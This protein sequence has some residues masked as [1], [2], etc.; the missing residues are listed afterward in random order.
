[1]KQGRMFAG[2][3]ICA[4]SLL[5]SFMLPQQVSSAEK[6]TFSGAKPTEYP[7][8]FKESFLEFAD[9]I[10]ESTEQGKRV[11][12]F[13]HQ[14]GCPY[15]N[16][17]VERNLSQ[18]DIVEKIQGNFDVIELNIWG[19]R[20]VVGIDGSEMTEKEFAASVSVQ[21]TPTLLF[22]D[23]AGQSVLRLNG[24]VP[25]RQFKVAL[26]YV[27]GH[28][29]TELT[30]RDFLE[31]N[32]PPPKAGRKMISESFF[33]QEPFN[34]DRSNGAQ[35]K[36]IAVFFEQADCPNCVT[37][38]HEVL[39]DEPTRQEI[40]AFDAIQ[41]DM[42]SYKTK[43]VIPSGQTMTARDWANE[44]DIAYAPTIVL[45]DASGNEV[46][47]SEAW[48]KIFHTQSLFAYVGSEAFRTEPNFQRYIAARADHLM[49]QGIDVDIWR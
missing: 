28:H 42:W 30:Y 14:D 25:P 10:A 32:L 39:V 22:Y 12:L 24:Y 40:A 23:E 43:V 35:D 2:A 49:E 5:T 41:L 6:G 18:K 21:F 29:E 3:L 16:A 15:C 45:F 38:H 34:L 44:L 1:M 26:E 17:L 48:F 47:R 9:D 37:L 11:L 4:I 20:E 36:P 13:F 27:A 46:I 7:E 33:A 31:L 8:W 19:D